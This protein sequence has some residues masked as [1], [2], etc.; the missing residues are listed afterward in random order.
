M[1]GIW[2]R[3]MLVGLVAMAMLVVAACAPAAEPPGEPSAPAAEAPEVITIKLQS[4]A[5]PGE[6]WR[7]E[8]FQQ[9]VKE[10]SNGR[11]EFKLFSGGEIVPTVE[12]L[13]AVGSGVLDMAFG[14]G[15]Y[16]MDKIPVAGVEYGLPFSWQAPGLDMYVVF[17]ERGLMD[18]VREAYAEHNTY[19]LGPVHTD[20]YALLATKECQTV[21]DLQNLKIRTTGG[22]AQALENS[23]IST[24]FLP[25][26]E[27]YV[28]LATGT[29]DGTIYG[30]ASGYRDMKLNEVAK[31]YYKP[32]V[33]ACAV[34][35]QFINMDLWN[36]LSP[37]LQAILVY[38][39]SDFSQWM[40][41]NY[42]D[43]EY[44]AIESMRKEGLKVVTLPDETMAELTRAALPVWD[45][46]ASASPRAA[47]GVEIVKDW[48]RTKGVLE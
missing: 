2:S 9:E 13:D 28:G 27:M 48:F 33:Q 34:C 29:I 44:Q 17:W 1:K 41:F 26:E 47:K 24:V 11:L 4:L 18:L 45:E 10:M 16:Y 12:T 15:A 46:L 19:Y 20:P 30:G 40:T 43:M 8:K 35:N 31:Y 25:A 21:A 23:G 36:S 39:T 37:D 7:F 22:V 42:M 38:A 14:C 5:A 32:P 6:M 3:G